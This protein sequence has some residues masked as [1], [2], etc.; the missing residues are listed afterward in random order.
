MNYIKRP[1]YLDFLRRHRDRPIIKVVSG[2]RR[3]GKSVLFQLYKEELLATGVDEDQII[4]INFED[5]S[6]YDLRHFQTLFAYIKD[7]LV[8]K[9]TYYIFLDEIQYVEKFELV[10]DS[11][12]I[13]ANVDLYLTGSNAYFMSSQLATNLTGRYVEIEVLPLSFEEYLSGQSLTENLNTTEIFNNYLFSAFP[14][15]LQTSSY[16]EK[17]DYLRGIYNSILLNDIVTRLGKPNPTIIERIVRTLLSSTGS[18]ISTNKIRNTL[19]SQNV[20][21]SHNT[22]ENY[23]TTLTDSLLFY[24]VPRFDVKGRALLQRLEKYYPVD[25]GLRHLLLPDHKEDIRHILENMV[26]LELRRRYS[27]VYVGNLDKYEVDFV[28]VT[29]LGHYAYYQ[30]SETTLAPETLER[31]LRPLEA[32]KDQ[33]PK[34]LLTMDTIHPTANYNGIEKK[35]IIDWL[36]EK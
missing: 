22:L 2:V 6:Y 3:A 19:V 18:L 26:Y 7:Q 12:F 8:S 27:Q 21:I 16:D 14:Y 32:I 31:E 24:S 20:S 13:L 5:L 23:L 10:A 11:L 17:I 33:F 9:K 35:N 29:D 25:L 1:H 30:V 36:L 4:F 28:V 15:L 34:Y